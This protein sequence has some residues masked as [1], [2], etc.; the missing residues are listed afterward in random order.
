MANRLLFAYDFAKR[1]AIVAIFVGM[2][3]GLAPPLAYLG[4]KWH[5]ISRNAAV[6]GDETAGKIRQ[7]VRENPDLWYYGIHKF[8]DE[9]AVVEDRNGILAIQVYDAKNILRF[10][11]QLNNDN[12]WKLTTRTPVQYNNELYG[13]LDIQESI[14][15]MLTETLVLMMFCL[16]LGIAVGN[17]V[18]RYPVRL[19]E[20]AEKKVYY[21]TLQAKRQADNEVAR[22]ER[23]SLVGQMAA[24]I[25][26][27]IR[28]PLTTVRGYLQYFS[29]KNEFRTFNSQ[30]QL[31]LDELDRSNSIITEFL[32]LAHNKAVTITNCQLPQVI[33]AMFPLL[34]S[35]ASLRGMSIT[36]DLQTTPDIMA[37][38]KEIRQLI[39]NIA[40][41]GFEAM[42]PHGVLTI[43]TACEPNS[44]LLQVIDQGSGI[45]PAI[46][47]QLGTPFITTKETGTGLGL[48]VCYSIANRHKASINFTSSTSGTTCSICFP[49]AETL[50]LT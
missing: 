38:E 24:A 8:L 30:F 33:E 18:Y 45:D 16:V 49:F 15:D 29:Q 35:D 48:A 20:F 32:N 40:R 4:V 7:M 41:N 13:F 46:L 2:I 14:Q 6:R 44:V 26:H 17:F 31:M 1:M 37:D 11:Q 43:K 28:N 21:Y 39:L 5:D 36:L 27:E 9:T 47:A 22:L 50:S 19:V 10:T 3:I 42:P 23:L 25:G 34:Q 12:A